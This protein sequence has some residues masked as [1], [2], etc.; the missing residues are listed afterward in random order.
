MY[1]K[2]IA[3]QLPP[4]LSPNATKPLIIQGENVLVDDYGF[5]ASVSGEINSPMMG[6]EAWQMS[7]KNA[8]IDILKNNLS[9]GS[10]SGSMA[11]AALDNK[12]LGYS[13]TISSRNKE[14]DYNFQVLLNDTMQFKLINT[15]QLSLTNDSYISLSGS[16]DG[17]ALVAQANLNGYASVGDAESNTNIERLRFEQLKLSSAAPYLQGGYFALDTKEPMQLGSLPIS[18][19]NVSLNLTDVNAALGLNVQVALMGEGDKN[20]ISAATGLT[21][22]AKN[23]H[24]WKYDGMD[25]SAISLDVNY[26]A[27][28]LKGTIEIFKKEPTYGTG[29]RGDIK[30]K[31]SSLPSEV[32]AECRFGKIDSEAEKFNYWFARVGA[33]VSI[34][35]GPAL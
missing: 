26:S 32:E 17:K 7:V 30:L 22:K 6:S 29:F 33:P 31:I 4:K 8:G 13:A 27:F 16:T 2:K 19:S 25:V 24:G 35:V 5:T 23:E 11:F 9:G 10:L 18:L 12:E 34:P 21:F 3:V 28:T 14:V 20:G 1:A 15:L